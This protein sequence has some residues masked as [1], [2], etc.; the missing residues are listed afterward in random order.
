MRM[1]EGRSIFEMIVLINIR[2]NPM[3]RTGYLK[4]SGQFLFLFISKV[5]YKCRCEAWT[6]KNGEDWNR[7]PMNETK[8]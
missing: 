5:Y 6:R 8:G 7:G 4:I 1:K 3:E 2:Y